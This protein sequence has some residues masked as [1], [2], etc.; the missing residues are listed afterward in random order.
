MNF[1]KDVE[2]KNVELKKI[3][4][5]EYGDNFS[6]TFLEF[7]FKS[8]ASASIAQVHKAKSADGKLVAVKILRPRI[9]KIMARDIVT[10]KIIIWI[11]SLFSKFLAKSL[12]DIALLLNDLQRSELD[13]LREASNASRSLFVN[14]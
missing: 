8:V 11:I 5:E 12:S 1:L 10:L 7:D 2:K 9:A 6:T 4:K 3:L 13:L 14:V